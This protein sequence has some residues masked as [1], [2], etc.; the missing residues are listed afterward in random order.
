MVAMLVVGTILLFLGMDA[1][2]LAS[3]RYANRKP[4]PDAIWSPEM[5]C[6]CMADGGEPIKKEDKKS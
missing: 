4:A 5:N 1:L 2:V 6:W 3:R